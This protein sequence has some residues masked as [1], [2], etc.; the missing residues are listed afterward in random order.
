MFYVFKSDENSTLDLYVLCLYNVQHLI[1]HSKLY[2]M[3]MYGKHNNE[4]KAKE[5]KKLEENVSSK[6]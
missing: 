2:F 4:E 3:I 5:V 6:Y 1:N